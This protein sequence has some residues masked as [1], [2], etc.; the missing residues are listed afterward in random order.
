MRLSTSSWPE[1]EAYLA[2]SKGIVIPIGSHEQHGPNGL[3]GTDAIC[4]EAIA[5]EAAEEAGF[6]VGP[7]FAVGQAQHH[8][9]FPGSITLRPSTMIAAMQDWIASLVRH[10][11]TRIYFL[12]GH[13]GNVATI[14]A[15]FSEAYAGWSLRG[16]PAPFALTSVNWWEL[17][18]VS[19]AI[20]AIFP[21]GDGAHATASEVSVTYYR[22]PEA[23]KRVAMEPKIAPMGSF[24]DA[25]DYRA[26]FADGRIG[27][28]PSQ[29]SVEAGAEI[30]AVAKRALIAE[31]T[32]FFQQS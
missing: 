9:A 29:A 4:P 18:G 20:R 30:V 17:P 23:V 7:T 8:M 2:R 31:T 25:A 19:A 5:L 10:G 3:I 24:R 16:E 14:Q 27:S 1:V 21:V 28:D 12:N 11:F 15:A 6:L 13:G 32:R 26:R 22:H